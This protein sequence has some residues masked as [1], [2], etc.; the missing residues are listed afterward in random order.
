MCYEDIINSKSDNK[1]S[2][3][4]QKK[5]IQKKEEDQKDIQI[6]GCHQNISNPYNQNLIPPQTNS[7]PL[8]EIIFD[9]SSVNQIKDSPE[10]DLQNQTEIIDIEQKQNIPQHK[11]KTNEV[12]NKKKDWCTWSAQE[13][14]LFYEIIANGGNYSSLQKLFKTMNYVRYII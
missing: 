11:R 14:L 6:E 3:V 7:N 2:D 13:K 1:K 9:I 12:N 8:K 10:E 4:N 5:I